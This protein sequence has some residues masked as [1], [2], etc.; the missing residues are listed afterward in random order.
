M[1]VVALCFTACK[2]DPTGNPIESGT[3]GNLSWTLTDNGTLHIKGSGEMPNYAFYYDIIAKQTI[4]W[5]SYKNSIKT[6]V[7]NSGV[8]N[9]GDYAFYDCSVL[10]SI[11]IPNSVTSIGNDAFYGCSYLTSI[12]IPDHI[13]CIEHG[14][15][16]NCVKLTSVTIPSEVTNVGYR[17]FEG[18]SALTEITVKT[19]LPPA[20]FNSDSFKNVNR[21]IPVY[22]PQESLQAYKDAPVWSEFTN[23]QGKVF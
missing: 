13:T 4:P 22:V 14:V 16:I 19:I 12:T 5:Y 11:T 8:T 18:C 17:A 7:I 23:L 21:S 2:D 20:V 1:L 9:I 6:V 3:T 10:K 15:F